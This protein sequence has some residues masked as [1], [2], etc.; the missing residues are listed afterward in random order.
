MATTG[1][2]PDPARGADPLA[3]LPEMLTVEEAAAM[4]RV[5]RNTVYDLVARGEIPGVRRVGRIFR[6]SRRV[7]LDWIEGAG[8]SDRG[9]ARRR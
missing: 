3:S 8:G 1:N 7:H 5:N 6:L 2:D 9:R 4:L